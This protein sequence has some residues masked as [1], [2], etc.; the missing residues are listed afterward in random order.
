LPD[1]TL[2][3]RSSSAELQQMRWSAQRLEAIVKHAARQ[4]GGL[5]R[6]ADFGDFRGQLLDQSN[7]QRLFVRLSVWTAER[8]FPVL[9]K[10]SHG[11][12]AMAC[13]REIIVFE[14]FQLRLR[15][16]GLV[17]APLQR[18]FALRSTARVT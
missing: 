7:R 8:K 3:T 6:G 1:Q 4:V 14:R 9:L 17:P 12:L 10:V 13:V 18:Y 16:L 15:D 5:R 11:L 2:P